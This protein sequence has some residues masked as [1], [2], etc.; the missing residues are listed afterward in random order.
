MSDYHILDGNR[1]GNTYR[2]IIHV[3]IPDDLNAL[4]NSIRAAISQCRMLPD[5]TWPK[6]AVPFITTD[7][8]GELDN[9]VKVEGEAILNTN[10]SEPLNI[11]TINLDKLVVIESDKLLMEWVNKVQYW[12]FSGDVGK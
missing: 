9:G 12:G 11:K 10:P 6:S 8:Q 1:D 3:A 5:G 7:E 2:V 4:G